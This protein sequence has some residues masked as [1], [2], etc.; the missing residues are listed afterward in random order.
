MRLAFSIK[1]VFILISYS[2]IFGF[3]FSFARWS[4]ENLLTFS[5]MSFLV[6]FFLMS[7]Q[8]WMAHRKHMYV[9]MAFSYWALFVSLVLCIVSNGSIIL[10][11]PPGII[12]EKHEHV[13][14]KMQGFREF[15]KIGFAGIFVTILFGLLFSQLEALTSILFYIV[16]VSLLPL[17]FIFRYFEPHSGNLPG[18][19][20]FYR[21]RT[22]YVFTLIFFLASSLMAL[23]GE[24]LF[25]LFFGLMVGLFG[26]LYYIIKIEKNF[27]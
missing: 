9:S 5:A 11:I 20:I 21:S 13:G 8:K 2:F 17:D 16:F 3:L 18:T 24:V 26:S 19:L 1:E 12:L 6:L 22:L 7:G 15:A 4:I 25:T 14:K 10:P 27:S 23:S